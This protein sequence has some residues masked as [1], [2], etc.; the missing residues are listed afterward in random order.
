[1]IIQ[2]QGFEYKIDEVLLAEKL[3]QRLFNILKF[4]P[5]INPKDLIDWDPDAMHLLFLNYLNNFKLILESATL[6]HYD[7]STNIDIFI[8]KSVKID[9]TK[10]VVSLPDNLADS[11]RICLIEYYCYIYSFFIELLTILLPNSKT[12][13]NNIFTEIH[14]APNLLW[15]NNFLDLIKGLIPE[16]RLKS[17]NTNHFDYIKSHVKKLKTNNLNHSILVRKKNK[18][19]FERLIDNVFTLSSMITE[20][21]KKQL[22]TFFHYHGSESKIIIPMLFEVDEDAAF[23]IAFFIRE[24]GAAQKTKAN[25]ISRVHNVS[26]WLNAN[27]LVK[28]TKDKWSDF[29]NYHKQ[30]KKARRKENLNRISN[31]ISSLL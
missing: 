11:D 18:E 1:M 7:T 26:C 10:G 19:E 21:Q 12:V 14:Y 24:I 5:G 2:I 13:E 22:K 17:C 25:V 29:K 28:S 30:F 20:S 3:S 8:S 27:L 16:H 23:Y 4:T 15:V 9:L 31:N 6:P